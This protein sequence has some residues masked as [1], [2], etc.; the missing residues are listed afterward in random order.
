MLSCGSVVVVV[1]FTW[2]IA[3]VYA[4]RQMPLPNWSITKASAEIVHALSRDTIERPLTCIHRIVENAANPLPNASL[5]LIDATSYPATVPGTVLSNLVEN[6]AFDDL[7][8]EDTPERDL[9]YKDNLSRVPDVNQTGRAYYTYVWQPRVTQNRATQNR[10]GSQLHQPHTIRPDR[11]TV[12]ENAALSHTQDGPTHRTWLFLRGA[13]YIST[14]VWTDAEGTHHVIGS[15]EGMWSRNLYDVTGLE[16][17]RV[18]VVV[19]PPQHCGIVTSACALTTEKCGPRGGLLCAKNRTEPCG[20]GGDHQLARDAG[21][22][23]FAAGWDWAQ[24]IPDRVTGL[25]DTASLLHTGYVLVRHATVDTLHLSGSSGIPVRKQQKRDE[26]EEAAECVSAVLQAR[27]ELVNTH[28]TLPITGTAEFVLDGTD[29]GLNVRHTVQVVVQPEETKRVRFGD[30][31]VGGIHVGC[32]RLWWPHSLGTGPHLYQAHVSFTVD[33]PVE[34]KA[35]P[36]AR[37][38]RTPYGTVRLRHG[39]AGLTTGPDEKQ[40]ASVA[41]VS[42]MEVFHVGIKTSEAYIDGHTKGRAFRIN[43]HRVFLQGGNWI[44]TDAML[45]YSG[46]ANRYEAEVRLHRE[47]GLNLIRV[48]GG[49]LTERPEFYEACD[50]LG[51]LVMQEF[52]MTGDN[53]GRWAG[54]YSWPDNPSS[55]LHQA[56]DMIKMV[57]SHVSLL[58]WCFGNELWPETLNPSKDI[59][60]GLESLLSTLDPTR[61]YIQSS[62]DIG[63]NTTLPNSTADHNDSYALTPKDGPY[64]FLE[65]ECYYREHNPGLDPVDGEPLYISFNPEIGATAIPYKM[66]DMVSMLGQE[67][68]E[69]YPDATDESSDRMWDYHKYESANALQRDSNA[70]R[71]TVYVYGPPDDTT[72]WLAQAYLA[73]IKQYQSMVEGFGSKMFLDRAR[74]GKSAMLVWKTQ[75]PWPAL[76][77]F[78]YTHRTLAVTGMWAG[79]RAGMVNWDGIHPQLNLHTMRVEAVNRGLRNYTTKLRAEIDFFDF[80]GEPV[81]NSEGDKLEL[82]IDSGVLAMS[83]AASAET[84]VWPTQRHDETL[85]VRVRLCAESDMVLD[86]RVPTYP[87]PL[88]SSHTTIQ[89]ESKTPVAAQP[90]SWYWLRRDRY[91]QVGQWS[92][93][94]TDLGEWRKDKRS[95]TSLTCTAYLHSDCLSIHLVLAVTK[96]VLF[97]PYVEALDAG[98]KVVPLVPNSYMPMVVLPKTTVEVDFGSVSNDVHHTLQTISTLEVTMWAGEPCVIRM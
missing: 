12:L 70:T 10:A 11:D 31:D 66:R 17:S 83:V 26:A 21:A 96:N 15:A 92:H 27:V 86:E 1:F 25:Y 82:S 91:S 90:A 22:M 44:A 95:H 93:N 62:M 88:C 7:L 32:V 4:H 97:A 51:V 43:G 72:E 29:G 77:G 73:Q 41:E 76:R 78:L 89:P 34:D 20:Q 36:N 65:P 61:F 30:G 85:F 64:H 52:W 28:P 60:S 79:I 23:Q 3:I 45:R 87:A 48:W 81:A 94:Y 56:E 35:S 71:S 8:W 47:A 46:D 57:R 2:H 37:V 67:S 74:G 18:A 53:N 42:D 84:I 14:V 9:Y 38:S 19:E 59:A 50:R 68:A 80:S 5:T 39:R 54:S 55:Y 58:F 16:L 75:S 6:R 98:G 33:E 49:G 69:V 13:G 40:G 63:R 24:G